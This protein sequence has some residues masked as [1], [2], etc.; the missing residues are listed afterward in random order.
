[1][2]RRKVQI[3]DAARMSADGAPSTRLTL[4]NEGL[5]RWDDVSAERRFLSALASYHERTRGSPRRTA[6]LRRPSTSAS[7]WDRTAGSRAFEPSGGWAGAESIRPAVR[8]RQGRY[9][10]LAPSVLLA[11]ELETLQ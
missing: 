7:W 2:N 4:W 6:P 9:Q 11:A 10:L 5:R 3:P 8:L 1:M